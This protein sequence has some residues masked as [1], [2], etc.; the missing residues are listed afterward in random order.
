VDLKFKEDVVD[1]YLKEINT[2]LVKLLAAQ[3][4]AENP[5]MFKRSTQ[6]PVPNLPAVPE[7]QIAREPST[8]TKRKQSSGATESSAPKRLRLTPTITF[9]YLNDGKILEFQRRSLEVGTGGNVNLD[10]SKLGSCVG[11][12]KRHASIYYE[13]VTGRWELLNY[14]EGGTVVNGV[15]YG[16][17]TSH[18]A[19][20]S[21]PQD[22][23]MR[24]FKEI[25]DRRKRT[26]IAQRNPNEN[27]SS[28]L[29]K[30]SLKNRDGVVE[31]NGKK[32]T[33]FFSFPARELFMFPR[34]GW[35]TNRVLG[36]EC[37][38]PEGRYRPVGLSQICY[39]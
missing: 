27:L 8:A 9:V 31:R 36:R 25:V 14:G 34:G 16:C 11:V 6:P 26:V 28:I 3:K 5:K 12:S 19:A 10:L 22:E 33:N 20:M 29:A 17:D 4:L 35:E 2:D 7:E 32:S 18:Y 21:K 38:N 24:H 39:R 1:D 23:T 13:Q 15:L 37:C 30:V